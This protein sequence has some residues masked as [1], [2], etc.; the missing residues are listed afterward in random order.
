[1]TLQRRPLYC[2]ALR[3]WINAVAPVMHG[4]GVGREPNTEY[5][6][7]M[8]RADIASTGLEQREQVG[9][10][11]RYVR[12]TVVQ[13]DPVSASRCNPPHNLAIV[14]VGCCKNYSVSSSED[15]SVCRR[16]TTPR[17]HKDTV[18]TLPFL[19]AEPLRACH[20][21]TAHTRTQQGP[22]ET[23]RVSEV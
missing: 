1:M 5:R 8:G 18:P 17:V 12:A 20:S 7:S 15:W 11:D 21:V 4:R 3:F 14:K 6:T 22:H 19:S 2:C 23:K 9:W 10:L 13:L 16:L